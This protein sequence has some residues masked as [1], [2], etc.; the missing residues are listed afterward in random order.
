VKRAL[1]VSLVLALALPAA[2]SAHA[3]LLFTSPADGQVLDSAPRALIVHFDDGV[4]VGPG[5]AAVDATGRSLVDGTPRAQGKTLTIPLRPSRDRT[6]EVRWSVVSD[7]GHNVTGVVAFT[8]RGAKLQAQKTLTAGSSNPSATDIAKRW[9][10]FAG[11][12]VAA[13]AALFLLAVASTRRVALLA[14]AAFAVATVGAVLLRAGVPAS[15]RFAHAMTVAAI[16]AAVG[17]LLAAIDVRR[18]LVLPALVLLAAPAVGGHAYDDGVPRIQVLVDFLHLSGAAAWTGGLAAL[19]LTI[20][21]ARR[22]SRLALPAV[23]L[24]A[25]TGV[26]RAISELTSVS[27]LWSTGYGRAILIK[28]ALFAAL[29][30][31]GYI[32]RSRLLTQPAALRRSVAVELGLLAALVVAVA[33]LTALPPGRSLAAPHAAAAPA[34][35]G[36]A[37]PPP[38]NA[39][40]LAGHTG[41]SAVAVA[42]QKN[43]ERL[44]VTTTVLNNQGN[45]ADGLAVTVNGSTA[46]RCGFGCYRSSVAPSRNLRVLVNG[47]PVTFALPP[48]PAPDGRAMLDRIGKQFMRT[49]SARFH[50]VLS[51]GPGQ[52]VVSD[53]RIAAPD[54]LAYTASDG[55]AGVIIGGRRWDRQN[56]GKWVESPQAP[57]VAQP[58]L[59]WAKAVYDVRVLPAPPSLVRVSFVDPATPAWYTV[60]ADRRTSRVRRIEMV[61]PAHFMRDTYRSYDTAP[62]IAPPR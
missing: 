23:G 53:W 18:V 37:P 54:S 5:I 1:L 58:Q 45:G 20:G 27:Q 4:T 16:A 34:A 17:A 35:T 48:L 24:I 42:V 51:S 14:T 36:A 50:E 3:R 6:Y 47:A 25:L 2:A 13:G 38:R 7:D 44:D 33:F 11:A 9:L 40:T 61:A 21:S 10:F 49:R 15:T 19:A 41:N 12:L 29:L 28:S 39:L 46:E 31:L 32:A 55:A 62:G 22:F 59:P 43:G 56:G 60:S 57:H 26:L 30:G 52:T 8:E